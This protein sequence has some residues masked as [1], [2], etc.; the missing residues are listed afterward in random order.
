MS[1]SIVPLDNQVPSEPKTIIVHPAQVVLCAPIGSGKT[2]LLNN[3]FR[4]S[5]FFKGFFDRIVI[6]SPLPLWLDAKWQGLL[7]MK[8]V[9]RKKPSPKGTD[10]T[11]LIPLYDNDGTGKKRKKDPRRINPADIH[12]EFDPDA[13]Q[14]ILEEQKDALEEGSY[15]LCVVFEDCPGL[16]MF[17]GKKGKIMLKLATTLRHYQ[18]TTF[19]C[20]QS[21][22]LLPRTVRNNCTH[23]IVWNIQN[24]GERRR[25][26][27]EHPMVGGFDKFNNLFDALMRTNGHPFIFFNFR[28]PI[29]KQIVL[30]FDVIV[31]T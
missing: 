7:D 9:L 8:G 20:T 31:D 12:I 29:G 17:T 30:N 14:D 18:C 15:R 11:N 23:M 13:L 19:Y 25:I 16:D 27:A 24:I 10:N 3:L 2:T 26:H 5:V 1:Y 21:Y 28:N 22:M 6:F 4:K